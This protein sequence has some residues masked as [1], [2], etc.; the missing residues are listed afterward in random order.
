M[1]AYGT[2]TRNVVPNNA[3]VEGNL[4]R[5][6][7][8]DPGLGANAT[9]SFTFG[10]GRITGANGSL[11]A[12]VNSGVGSTTPGFAVGVDVLVVGAVINDGATFRVTA[13]DTT[14]ASYLTVTP[15]PKAEGPITCTVR[16]T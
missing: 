1:P 6:F 13:V 15:P 9:A 5:S 4:T 11:P 16:T 7:T 8:R 3:P 12:S 10:S 2:R 14:N